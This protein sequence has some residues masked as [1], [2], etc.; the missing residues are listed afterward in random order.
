MEELM[1]VTYL[2][3]NKEAPFVQ[4]NQKNCFQSQGLRGLIVYTVRERNNCNI[5]VMDN[6]FLIY[7][8]KEELIRKMPK[9]TSTTPN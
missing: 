2:Y 4:S 5:L 3:C 8:G 9:A 1:R 6:P 7:I